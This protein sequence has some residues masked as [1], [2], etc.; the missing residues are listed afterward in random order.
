MLEVVWKYQAC[1]VLTNEN[2]AF[3]EPALSQMRLRTLRQ[4]W[5]EPHLRK[6][7]KNLLSVRKCPLRCQPGMSVGVGVTKKSCITFGFSQYGRGKGAFKY[8]ISTFGGGWLILH[9]LSKRKIYQHVFFVVE[10]QSLDKI[11][12]ILIKCTWFQVKK[13]TRRCRI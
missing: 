6:L 3:L 10:L 7:E 5:G 1:G 11:K 4:T 8:Y 12:Q 13:F 9:I 2:A